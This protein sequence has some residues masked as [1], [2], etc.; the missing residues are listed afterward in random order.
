[1]FGIE[2]RN[3]VLRVIDSAVLS[4][5]Q[6][7]YSEQF[8]GGPE[9]R[10][11]EQEWQEYFKVKNAI[12]CN[13]ATSG[14]W[15]ACAVIG[16]K[17]RDEIIVSPFSMTCSAS[18]PLQF[19]AK[20]VFSDI[21]ENYF[22]LDPID[23]EKKITERTKAIIAVDLFGLPCDFDK[24]NA[25]ADRHGLIVI[26]DAA[27]AAGATYKGRYAGTLSDIGVFS[28]NRH[29]IINCGEGGVITTNDDDL[30]FKLRLVCNH[31]EAVVNDMQRQGIEDCQK[32]ANI[33][34]GM[35]LR[36]TELQACIAREQ[37]KKLA[38]ILQVVRSVAP[39]F[40]VKV[41]PDCESSF[42]RYATTTKTKEELR[43]KCSSLVIENSINI[44]RH[45][46]TPLYRLP[47]FKHLGYTDNL[48]P[49]CEAV[50]ENVVLCW[51]KEGP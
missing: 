1:M 41:R 12:F 30:A 47:L 6:G 10:A 37:L 14:L 23:I 20:P 13:S 35:N 11:L 21:E 42:Y 8:F 31:S 28:L 26:E 22:C 15:A 9:V 3:A 43:R 19:G 16:L 40:D 39:V 51:L 46:T 49:T 45:Y 2:E 48:C 17:P 36:G 4:G 44:K 5:Y 50:E 24:I 25:I 34:P 7:N 29:K 32:Y 18:I 38:G 27:Q 33:W